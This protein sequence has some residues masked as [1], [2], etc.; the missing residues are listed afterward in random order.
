MVVGED[1]GT[2]PRRDDWNAHRLREP[3]EGIGAAS[4]QNS[5]TGKDQG[6]TGI[7]KQMQDLAHRSRIWLGL[8]LR[9]VGGRLHV[10][11]GRSRHQRIDHVGRH[12]DQDRAWAAP[13]GRCYCSLQNRP[14]L[15][16]V[17]DL[18]GPL[19]DWLEGPHEV[20]FLEGLATAQIASNLT[21]DGDDRRRIR[22]RGVQA[23]CQIACAHTTG[24]DANGRSAGELRDGFSHEGGR[25]FVA[26]SDHSNASGGQPFEKTEDA[27]ARNGEGNLDAGTSQPFS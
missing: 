27:F 23:Y 19:H 21:D 6:P 20:H 14:R 22:S 18:Y 5:R 10:R 17:L 3:N 2:A 11:S 15:T 24:P 8:M 16:W 4:A 25:P 13:G 26:R 1:V 12:R 9:T 7:S